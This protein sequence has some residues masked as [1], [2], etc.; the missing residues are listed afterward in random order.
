M[1]YGSSEPVATFVQ[2]KQEAA[3]VVERVRLR[4]RLD[5]RDVTDVFAQ[6]EADVVK[7]T[8]PGA[9]DVAAK[10]TREEKGPIVVVD[11]TR[12]TL[13]GRQRVRQYSIPAGADLYRITCMAAPN[14]FQ[15]HEGLMTAM[16]GSFKGSAELGAAP[17]APA[18]RR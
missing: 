4:Q 8:Q 16:V 7:E 18:S 5:P 6:I 14:Q 1:I 3:I 15:R 13:G 9:A 10:L 17:S 11:Y 2:G 12:E